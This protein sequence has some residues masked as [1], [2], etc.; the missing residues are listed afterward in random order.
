VIKGD[1]DRMTDAMIQ[2]V[3]QGG[4]LPRRLVLGAGAY[5]R[6]RA[7]LTRRIEELDDQKAIAIAADFTDEELAGPSSGRLEAA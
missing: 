2:L 5:A 6:V 1:P 3:D 7:E 4:S